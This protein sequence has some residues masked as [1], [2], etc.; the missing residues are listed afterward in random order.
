MSVSDTP[1]FFF[2][3]F[4]KHEVRHILALFGGKVPKNRL[5]GQ[6]HQR[7]LPEKCVFDYFFAQRVL[8]V[9]LEASSVRRK[10]NCRATTK[11]ASKLIALSARAASARA[12]GN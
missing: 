11:T 2:F 12:E 9:F 5:K 7:N 8:V 3:K 6:K 4:E 1:F 10:T